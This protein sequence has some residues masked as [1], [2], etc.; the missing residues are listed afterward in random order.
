[1]AKLEGI[2]N[3]WA[4]IIS[5]ISN[6]PATNSIWSVIQRLVLGACVYFVWQERNFRCF[7]KEFRDVD[8]LF[9]IVV[10]TVRLKLLGLNIRYS[11]NSIEAA[12]IWDLK[13]LKNEYYRRMVDEILKHNY[14]ND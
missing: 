13:I 8:C 1:M 4:S 6:K 12:N 2:S 9:K 14:D 3:D 10:G 11:S 7:R 5:F